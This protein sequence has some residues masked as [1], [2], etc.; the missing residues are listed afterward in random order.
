MKKLLTA[1]LAVISAACISV[2]TLGV[3]AATAGIN[4]NSEKGLTE[5]SLSDANADKSS[6]KKL[7]DYWGNNEITFTEQ[8][9]YSVSNKTS[10]AFNLVGIFPLSGKGLSLEIGFPVRNPETG[11]FADEGFKADN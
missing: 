8:G 1:F 4:Y 7:F 10:N 2:G 3:F 5:I 9:A 6:V 11:D